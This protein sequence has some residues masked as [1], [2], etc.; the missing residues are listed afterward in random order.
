M[1]G[2]CSCIGNC[3]PPERYIWSSAGT[4]R[5]T[6][7]VAGAGTVEAVGNQMPALPYS[8]VSTR[9]VWEQAG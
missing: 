9:N 6:I 7:P 4:Q 2:G 3:N 1:D 5:Q 8:V